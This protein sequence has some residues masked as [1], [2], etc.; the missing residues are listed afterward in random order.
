MIRSEPESRVLSCTISGCMQ[1]EQSGL[2]VTRI[3]L[4]KPLS[5]VRLWKHRYVDRS[6]VLMI[7]GEA[8]LYEWLAHGM[9]KRHHLLQ[10]ASLSRHVYLAHGKRLSAI[11]VA[12]LGTTQ[13]F[14]D[15]AIRYRTLLG[16][17]T[18]SLLEGLFCSVGEFRGDGLSRKAELMQAENILLASRRSSIPLGPSS[19]NRQ[20]LQEL[21]A[22]KIHVLHDV[23][24]H[25]YPLTLQQRRR[26][27]LPLW[28]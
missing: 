13:M 9:V 26:C 8:G 15:V 27:E 21:T 2:H 14:E 25:R 1:G 17:R 22:C 4:A 23:M 6:S 28:L 24:M 3:T 12:T 10:S 11:T 5:T 16:R 19:A 20:I 7:V 18:A